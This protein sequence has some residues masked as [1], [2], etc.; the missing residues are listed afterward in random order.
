[1]KSNS[2][3]YSILN[4]HHLNTEITDLPSFNLSELKLPST[5][6]FNLPQNLR[7]GH[8]AEYIVA[9]S[10]KASSN[11][12]MLY[13]N[14]QIIQD[15]QTLGEIDFI[16]ENTT[17]HQQTHVELAY[18]FYLY[19]PKISTKQIN[20]WI[21]PNRNDSLIQ[22]LNKLKQK[23]FLL[24]HHP[25]TLATLQNIQTKTVS[26]ALCLLVSLFVPYQFKEELHPQYQKAIK[27]VYF[28]FKKFKQ[29][30]NNNKSY[31]L[32]PK[33]EWGI[34]PNQNE[35]WQSFQEIESQ[36]TAILKGNQAVLC[37]QKHQNK[38]EAFFI[39]WWE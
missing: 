38:F 23:Q 34:N 16:I 20:N 15:K 6:D 14:V 39:V 7:L 24:L 12:K 9:E 27:G 28:N 10:I 36:I 3:I 8:L 37:W 22:K 1:M 2:R 17:T 18:K 29:L 13:E 35:N 21:G 32:P 11:Y 4:A 25:A 5:I 33:T 31:F 30:H 26:K 19:D